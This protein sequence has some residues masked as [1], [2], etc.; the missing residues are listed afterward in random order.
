MREVVIVSGAR[1]AIG[2]YMGSLSGFSPV[3]L[4]VFALQ[5]AIAKAGIDK[6]IIQEVVAGQC[7]QAGA[8]GNTARHVAM[9]AEV[10]IESFAFM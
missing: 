4:G 7:N 2:N 1:T 8:P 10:P 5:G 6:N 9:R 3:E